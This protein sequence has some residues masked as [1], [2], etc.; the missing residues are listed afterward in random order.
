MEPSNLVGIDEAQYRNEVLLLPSEEVEAARDKRLLEEAHELGLK[1]PEVEVTASVAASIASGIIDISSP[2][3]SSSSSTDRN[4][5]YEVPHSYENPR[6]DQVASSLSE[7]TVSS[8]PMKCGS[9]RSIASLSTRPTSLCSSEGRLVTGLDGIF[10]GQPGHRNSLISLS[11]TD[12]KEKRKSSL[13]SAIGRIHFRKKRTPSTVLLPP[14]A[15]ITVA[16]GQGGVDRI[17]V[18]SRRSESQNP[19]SDEEGQSLRV[20]IPIYDKETLQRS[21]ENEEL[22]QLRELHKSE[23]DRHVAFQDSFLMQLRRNQQAVVADRLSENKAL[24]EQKRAKNE[25]DAARM[26]ERQLAVEMDQL[27]EFEREKQNSR[28]RIKYMEGYFNNAHPPTTSDS[29]SL[30]GSDQ[31]TPVRQYTNQQKSLLAQEY[32]DH[33]CMDQLHSAKIKVLRDRQEI[34]LQE[35]IA[36]MERELDALIDKHAL[37]FADLQRQHQREEALAMHAFETKKTKLRHRWNLEEAILRKK[38]ELQ[39]GHPYGPLPPLSFSDSHYETRDSA[40][41]VSE[42]SMNM[43]SDEQTH[44]KEGEESEPVH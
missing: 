32:H 26:E 25:A 42:N 28:T 43:S 34:R 36:R 38:L 14:A 8:D 9:L 31:T 19:S 16:R 18:E 29:E 1:V 6:L 40:I 23:R 41:C 37:E 3:L 13:K 10:A 5:I 24:E 39:H 20:E 44:P 30:S 33:E 2:V 35:A 15:Q 21:L 27:R 12:K 22:A 17:Y 4:S 7:L 11:S